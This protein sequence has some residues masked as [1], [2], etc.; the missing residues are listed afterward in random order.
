MPAKKQKPPF[1]VRNVL[2][3][4]TI[5]SMIPAL[6][7]IIVTG[8]EYGH[9]LE[10]SIR[11][12]VQ[13]QAESIAE[14]QGRSTDALLNMMDTVV[15][16]PAFREG[17]AEE[18]LEILEVVLWQNPRLLNLT[19]T[20][21]D[22]IVVVS[23]G[24]ERGTDLS[25]RRHVQDALRT[26][27]FA[28]GEYILARIDE[29]PSFPYAIPV[30]NR[31]NAITGILSA[32]Y[33]LD[34]FGEHFDRLDLPEGTIL[35]IT[36][37]HGVR[38][39]FHPALE[40]NPIGSPIK[41]DVWNAIVASPTGEGMVR[42]RGSDGKSRFYAFRRL[43]LGSQ[44]PYL[45]VVVGFPEELAMGPARRILVRNILLII[46]AVLAAMI[47]AVTLGNI[48]FTRRIDRLVD[49]ARAIEG[50]DLHART[51]LR[52]G[53]A[54]IHVIAAAIDDMAARLEIRVREREKEEARLA[55]S[56]QEKETLLKEIHHR[57]KNNMQ[58][59]L[60]IIHLQRDNVES[61][62]E[63]FYRNLE[64]RIAAMASVHEMLYQSPDLST[65][66]MQPFLEN[67]VQLVTYSAVPPQV[68]VQAG[69]ITLRIEA[70][71]P[72]ALITGEL[73]V[74]AGKYGAINGGGCT[75]S[76]AL[77]REDER[78]ILSV[79]DNGP[80]FP[81]GFSPEGGSGLGYSLISALTSQLGGT[82]HY[83]TDGGAHVRIELH[84]PGGIPT[85]L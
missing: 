47:T 2:L 65:I 23:P 16:L 26:G 1:T 5:A 84:V 31:Q 54:E 46:G 41:E 58:L 33:P 76:I 18:Q 40:T 20:D 63:D 74:N 72:L 37:R 51:G 70:A 39:Y 45:S 66:Q 50:G 52:D 22:G 77:F 19:V 78:L 64:T 28:A 49:T 12:E 62:A 30:R 55:R 9:T 56:L 48:V 73:M 60:S 17:N 13:R 38:V 69:D 80:G 15:H 35:G 4:T 43:A 36:D 34:S 7:V 59:I 61:M 57:V 14:I 53:P 27:S 6:I 71:V 42:S 44:T 83:W 75:V 24:L 8:T 81:E 67:L 21:T 68:L 32:V 10:R 25:D 85:Y 29:T 3:L 79:A 82:M 11:L